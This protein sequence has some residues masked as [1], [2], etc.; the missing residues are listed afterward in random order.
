MKTKERCLQFIEN[1]NDTAER[2]IVGNQYNRIPVDKMDAE[3][4]NI[5]RWVEYLQDSIEQEE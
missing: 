4:K 3:L 1:I 2:L 5:I